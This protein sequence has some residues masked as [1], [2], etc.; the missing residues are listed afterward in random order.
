M[1]G[2]IEPSYKSGKIPAQFNP[3]VSGASYRNRK[4]K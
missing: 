2:Q 3:D 4:I 1:N